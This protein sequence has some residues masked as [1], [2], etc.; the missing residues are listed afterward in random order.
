[1]G[2]GNDDAKTILENAVKGGDPGP[3]AQKAGL[4]EPDA[5]TRKLL[6]GPIDTVIDLYDG[7]PE[8][9]ERWDELVG[10]IG[11]QEKVAETAQEL[12][13]IASLLDEG[14]G[15]FDSIPPS[16]QNDA[17]VAM[18]TKWREILAS[19][20][21]SQETLAEL[22]AH[23][24]REP[25]WSYFTGRASPA[26]NEAIA[27]LWQSCHGEKPVGRKRPKSDGQTY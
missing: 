8:G 2:N 20:M 13:E 23:P 14:E 11:G 19:P 6:E 17:V 21:K 4:P 9:K 24:Q 16:E 27:K 7:N 10:R 18:V 22:Y 3:A 12:R 26:V 1:M 25:M 5:I 15:I